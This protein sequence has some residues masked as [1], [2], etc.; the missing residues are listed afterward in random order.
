VHVDST[1]YNNLYLR[2]SEP[3]Y[4]QGF[5]QTEGTIELNGKRINYTLRA[6]RNRPRLTIDSLLNEIKE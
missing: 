5:S 2:I 4:W 1:L 6:K 3:N